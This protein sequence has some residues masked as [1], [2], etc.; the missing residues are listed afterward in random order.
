MIA[1]FGVEFDCETSGSILFFQVKGSLECKV[2][3]MVVKFLKPFVNS[4]A[5][6]V[7]HMPGHV[8]VQ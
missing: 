2:C 7:S 1:P 5:T 8:I 6:E 4:S 3:E